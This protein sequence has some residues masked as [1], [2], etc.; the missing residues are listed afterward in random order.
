MK[1][2]IADYRWQGHRLLHILNLY[3]LLEPYSQDIFL[4]LPR[5]AYTSHYWTTQMNAVN[6]NEQNKLKIWENYKLSST[7]ITP[8]NFKKWVKNVIDTANE[9]DVS[10]LLFP[11]GDKMMIHISELQDQGYRL[12]HIHLLFGRSPRG[13]FDIDSNASAKTDE[14]ETL[15]K[16]ITLHGNVCIGRLCAAFDN[17]A[18]KKIPWLNQAG[19]NKW[20]VDPLAINDLPKKS[21]ARKD[22]NLHPS[23]RYALLIG[24]L[25]RRKKA[26]SVVRSW[27][28]IYTETGISLLLIGEVDRSVNNLPERVA[29]LKQF[30]NESVF[31]DF[32]Y[33]NHADFQNYIAAADVVICTY[34]KN[35]GGYMSSEVTGLAITMG[36]PCFVDGNTYIE[37]LITLNH[38]GIVGKIERKDSSK[39]ILSAVNMK[40]NKRNPK[41]VNYE[42]FFE[43]WVKPY[44]EKKESVV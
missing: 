21:I 19:N 10:L 25:S 36:T 34:N 40:L 4:N 17:H 43:Q 37:N 22:L 2:M 23:R 20:I 3:K 1:I 7:Q 27:K 15:M 18:G 13:F 39:D 30:N 32:S 26:L 24:D 42:A 29:G 5:D 31:F 33:V 38:K 44:L 35:L 12:P 14:Y 11:W 28:R 41:D 9:K 16:K 6:N 8:K